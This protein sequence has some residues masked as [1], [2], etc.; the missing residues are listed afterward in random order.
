MK[1]VASVIWCR[2]NNAGV[3]ARNSDSGAARS[4]Y[5]YKR[6]L[7]G[8]LPWRQPEAADAS[9]PATTAHGERQLWL[10]SLK[11]AA[12]VVVARAAC[13]YEPLCSTGRGTGVHAGAMTPRR[14]M[15]RSPVGRA[16]EATLPAGEWDEDPWRTF[17]RRS[18]TE[19]I[20]MRR[21]LLKEKAA[22][23]DGGTAGR[24][25]RRLSAGSD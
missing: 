13:I 2:S 15:T 11:A 14:V 23:D 16:S 8:I 4:S 12:A 25:C 5:N 24:G 18:L 21:F 7:C 22:H 6:A 3:R 9:P 1:I 19:D 17:R 20:L 10:S